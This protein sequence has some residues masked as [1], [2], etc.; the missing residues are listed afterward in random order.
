M[1][2]AM[3]KNEGHCDR[4]KISVGRGTDRQADTD[5]EVDDVGDGNLCH[6][7]LGEILHGRDGQTDG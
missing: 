3:T 5:D 7:D 6:R 4:S 1:T 2:V